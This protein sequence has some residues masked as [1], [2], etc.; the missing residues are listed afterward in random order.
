[1]NEKTVKLEST[2][3]SE[4]QMNVEKKKNKKRKKARKKSIF[5]IL[6]NLRFFTTFHV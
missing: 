3:H 6:D 5:V 4:K 2:E 1:M